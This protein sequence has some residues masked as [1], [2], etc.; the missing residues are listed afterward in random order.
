[1]ARFEKQLEQAIKDSKAGLHGRSLELWATIRL[2]QRAA[3]KSSTPQELTDR[4]DEL[5][6]E[7]TDLLVQA[8]LH[9][10]LEP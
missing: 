2:S 1:M 8:S 10:A 5:L 9:N 3:H 6:Q 7:L 4:E